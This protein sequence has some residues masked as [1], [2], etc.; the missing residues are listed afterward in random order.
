MTSKWW[1]PLLVASLALNL[2]LVGFFVG[3]Q[4]NTIPGFDPT[5]RYPIW[6]RGL[7]EDRRE[8]LRPIIREHFKN[9]RPFMHELRRRYTELHDSIT[10]QPFD[11]ERLNRALGQLRGG[12][13]NTQE[14]RHRGFVEFVS[15]LTPAERDAL[16]L[17]IIRKPPPTRERKKRPR[18]AQP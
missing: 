10:T 6:T 5:M 1:V 2:V 15:R 11:G 4:A 9:S 7:P 17:E 8:T 3:R 16:A 12:L 13:L 14:I 18:P